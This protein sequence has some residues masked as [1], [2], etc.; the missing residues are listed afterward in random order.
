MQY[1]YLCIFELKYYKNEIT[2]VTIVIRDN[3]VNL[4]LDLKQNSIF[5]VYLKNQW[6]ASFQFSTFEVAVLYWNFIF[7]SP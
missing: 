7:C 2:G 5:Y 1:A 6:Q 4:E 3:I